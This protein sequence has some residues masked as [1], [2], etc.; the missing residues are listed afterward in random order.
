[1]ED[2][3]KEI[4][5]KMVEDITTTLQNELQKMKTK[6]AEVK[7]NYQQSQRTIATLNAKVEELEEEVAKP[8]DAV[9]DDKVSFAAKDYNLKDAGKRW[10]DNSIYVIV[11]GVKKVD[12]GDKA[13]LEINFRRLN[14][15]PTKLNIIKAEE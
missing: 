14:I 4:A 1:M 5:D 11:D 2:S 15:D 8:I 7:H 6:Y 3:N 12:G 10:K 9:V 13:H